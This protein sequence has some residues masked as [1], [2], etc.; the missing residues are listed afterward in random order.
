MGR[1]IDVS[2][3][4]NRYFADDSGKSWI[5]VG[6]NICFFRNS[7]NFPEETVLETYREWLTAFANAGGNFVRIWL[8]VPFFDVM[9]RKPGEYDENA[10][11]HIR[12]IIK[13]CEA[14]GI[15]LKFTFEH[16]RRIMPD[17]NDI[18]AYAGAALFSKPIY[19]DLV[20]NMSEYFASAECRKIYLDRARYFAAQGFGD[21]PAV[22][23][24]ELWN[25]IN[26]TAPMDEVA[27]WSDY[28]IAELQKIFPKQMI[29]QNIG[30]FS[31]PWA[32]KLYDY[33]AGVKDNGY[34][35]VHRYLDPGAE[36][37]ACT[38]PMDILCF[39]AIR[40]LRERNSNIPVVLAEVGACE[41][42]H[43]CYSNMYK[44]D[45]EGTLLHDG[46]FTPFF[47]GSA[48]SGQFWHWDHIYIHK[49]DLWYHF[50]RFVEAV[51][52]LDPAAE[53]F[54]PFHT[55]TPRTRVYGLIGEKTVIFWVRDKAGNWKSELVEGNPAEIISGEILDSVYGENQICD[56][57]LP[58][59]DRH[60]T[61]Q[62]ENGVCKFPDFKRS[63]VIRFSRS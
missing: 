25:E 56:C 12:F 31:C 21:S 54:R 57:Y 2:K 24:W 13:T 37:E 23:A 14:L 29:L 5:P 59:E 33:L 17:V 32:Y 45:K 18:E 38:G 36:I 61:T 58:W 15:K 63:M 3:V 34:L 26:N 47:S 8:G 9:P 39:D 6:C 43:S 10:T 35:Q 30:S 62:L 48:G 53:H 19:G 20:R 4:D 49:H 52:G 60:V 11:S 27:K 16:F 41:A 50:A 42:N 44:I 7:E 1:F 40:E 22:I 55:S 51:R 28:M 46:I